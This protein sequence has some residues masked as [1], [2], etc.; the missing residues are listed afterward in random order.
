MDLTSK[1]RRRGFSLIELMI[2]MALIL[3][4]AAMLAG[5]G[6]GSRQNRDLAKCEKNLQSIFTALTIYSSDN[7]G[8]YPF[9]SNAKTSEEPLSL[10]VPRSTTVTEMFIC[11]GTKDSRLPEAEPFAK[12]RISYAYYMGWN[13]NAPDLAP[14]VSDRQVNPQPKRVGDKLFSGDGKD[15][16]GNHHKYGGNVL[17]NSG[18]IQTSGTNVTIDLLFPTNVVFL[19]PKS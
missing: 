5:R 19:N 11:P 18:E 7:A 4:M 9:V 6:S 16:G 17:F 12:R 10:L 13:K 15:P 2:T 1:N 8:R 3:I 14:L